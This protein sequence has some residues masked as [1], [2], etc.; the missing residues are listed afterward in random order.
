SGRGGRGEREALE[1][2]RHQK[3]RD[4]RGAEAQPRKRELRQQRYR[5]P[6]E[7]AQITAHADH[8]IKTK[9][10]Q[11][12]A[13]ETVTRERLLGLALRTVVRAVA[14]GIGNRFGVLLDRA[15]ERV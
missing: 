3:Q 14:V 1:Q 5:A 8:A 13:I 7:E 11:R 2:S 15:D 12:A 9:I 10:D 6:A 4:H